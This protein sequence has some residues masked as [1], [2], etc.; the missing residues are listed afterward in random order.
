MAFSMAPT[1]TFAAANT[2]ENGRAE[3]RV[4]D[5]EDTLSDTEPLN[6]L[7]NQQEEPENGGNAAQ[8]EEE[9]ESEEPLSLDEPSMEED[10]YPPFFKLFCNSYLLGYGKTHARCLFTIS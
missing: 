4:S 10:R 1:E 8:T 3:G 5:A 9:Q 2:E 7:W 6:E